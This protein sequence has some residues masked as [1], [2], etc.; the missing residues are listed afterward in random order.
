MVTYINQLKFKSTKKRPLSFERLNLIVFPI[1][2]YFESQVE[3]KNQQQY[4]DL[5][6]KMQKSLT[7]WVKVIKNQKNLSLNATFEQL[8]NLFLVLN[9]DTSL[10]STAFVEFAKFLNEKG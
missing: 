10:K 5:A 1:F 2:K 3:G 4:G 7:D 6:E 9:N 8:L